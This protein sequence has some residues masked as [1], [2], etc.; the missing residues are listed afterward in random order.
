MVMQLT[1]DSLFCRRLLLIV[2][3]FALSFIS[4]AQTNSPVIFPDEEDL[5]PE[6]LKLVW[7]ATPGVRYEVMQ[8]TNLQSWSISPGFPAT[9]DGPA[10]QD[11]DGFLGEVPADD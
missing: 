10:Q 7:P 6:N 5:T 11:P 2:S 3:F 4:S 1:G 9:A 8:S